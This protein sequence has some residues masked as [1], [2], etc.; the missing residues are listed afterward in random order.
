[1]TWY[2]LDNR[3]IEAEKQTKNKREYLAK[4]KYNNIVCKKASNFKDI[5]GSELELNTQYRI[6]TDMSF[7][8]TTVI[9]Y[10]L[11]FYNID[12]LYI[13]V[14]RMNDKAFDFLSEI[15]KKDDIKTGFIVSTFFRENKK[16]E[17]WA[18]EIKILSQTSKNVKTSYYNSH[19]KV[20]LAKTKCDKHIVF[21]GSG[22]LSHNERLEQYIFE[23]NKNVY[24][25]HKN[26]IDKILN[27]EK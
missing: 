14:Y 21:E 2:D 11:E 15:I 24:D 20:F 23:N 13:V 1:M 19:A 22:N 26:W 25:F 9:Q 12:E 6:V 17:R 4:I 27:L 18:K 7:S 3:E 10:L 5:V 16:Y 8:A